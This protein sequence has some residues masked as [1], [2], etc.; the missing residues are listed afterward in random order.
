MS[1]KR[2]PDA[3][4]APGAPAAH[5]AAAGGQGRHGRHG[6]HGGG[7]EEAH[8]GA[9]EWLI[10]FADNVMLQMGFFVILLALAMKAPSGGGEGR[11]RGEDASTG[12]PAVSAEQL[13]FAIAVRAAFNNPVQLDSTDAR[14][15]LLVQR[16]LARQRGSGQAE[17]E[18]LE[19]A[20][21]DV[22]TVRE[23]GLFGAGGVVPFETDSAVLDDV[24][25]KCA[26]QLGAQFRGCRTMLEVRG[27]CSAAEAFQHP[28]RGMEL[29][30]QRAYVVAEVLVAQGLGWNQIRLTACADNDRINART[31]EDAGHRRNQRAEVIEIDQVAPDTPAAAP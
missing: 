15:V 17:Q 12:V 2:H 10:S 27:H 30:Y 6:P 21:H 1:E 7:H 23:G 14:D 16:L 8:E 22:R 11:R 3:Q 20:D 25:R 28:A 9:P 19:G 26:E 18:G 5:A 24:G 29:S 4:D 13:D 31:Y